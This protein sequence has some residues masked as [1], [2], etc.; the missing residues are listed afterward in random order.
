MPASDKFLD[1]G[2]AQA[3]CEKEFLLPRLDRRAI[4]HSILGFRVCQESLGQAYSQFS[5]SGSRVGY[6]V[7][8]PSRA[9]SGAGCR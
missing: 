1:D 9:A 7:D 2:T 5:M 4:H 8:Q 6:P 3:A